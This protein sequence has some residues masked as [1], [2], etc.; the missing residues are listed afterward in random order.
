MIQI[1]CDLFKSWSASWPSSFSTFG[2]TLIRTSISQVLHLHNVLECTRMQ[3]VLGREDLCPAKLPWDRLMGHFLFSLRQSRV[4]QT[5][6]NGLNKIAYCWL[7][8]SHPHCKQCLRGFILYYLNFVF[9]LLGFCKTTSSGLPE[10]LSLRKSCIIKGDFW[11]HLILMC[12]GGIYIIC[13][14]IIYALKG[15]FFLRE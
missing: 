15:N 1:F 4:Q 10:W 12:L 7:F 9:Y 3:L 2:V 11:V 5:E 13:T 8:A 14:C 6:R